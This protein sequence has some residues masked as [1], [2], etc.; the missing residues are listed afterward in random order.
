M[1]KSGK[2]RNIFDALGRE[3]VRSKY[4]EKPMEEFAR[5][6]KMTAAGLR[7]IADCLDDEVETKFQGFLNDGTFSASH[8]PG[9]DYDLAKIE[10]ESNPYPGS[11]FEI[12]RNVKDLLEKAL[13]A[14]N[15]VCTQRAVLNSL[16]ASALAEYIHKSDGSMPYS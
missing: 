8:Q 2:T 13:R 14:E 5:F 4:E 9:A 6:R 3:V 10:V 12:P 15:R 1:S 16:I 7:V 11:V